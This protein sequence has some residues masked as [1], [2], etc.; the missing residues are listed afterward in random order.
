MNKLLFFIAIISLALVACQDPN[1]LEQS[2]GS[3]EGAAQSTEAHDD[4][5]DENE[6]FELLEARLDTLEAMA[7]EDSVCVTRWMAV[8]DDD[9]ERLKQLERSLREKHGTDVPSQYRQR[10]QAIEARFAGVNVN[11]TPKIDPGC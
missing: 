7:E 3:E 2:V 4:D 6:Y 8:S 1:T 10:A 9:G 11:L 5:S